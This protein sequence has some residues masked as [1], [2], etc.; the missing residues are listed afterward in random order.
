M[1]GGYPSEFKG[2]SNKVDQVSWDYASEFIHRLNQKEGHSCY[3]LPTEAEWEYAAR[4]GSTSIYSFWVEQNKD[5]K[6]ASK[7]PSPRG[8]WPQRS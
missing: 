6:P 5:L 7:V 8:G 3:R 4:A 1:M 2:R